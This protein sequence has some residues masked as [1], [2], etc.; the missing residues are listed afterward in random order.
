MNNQNKC[1]EKLEKAF[2]LENYS[3]EPKSE[4]LIEIKPEKKD[5]GN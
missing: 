5:K 4:E 2:G 3:E 1:P